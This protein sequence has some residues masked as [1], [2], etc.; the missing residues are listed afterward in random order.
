MSGKGD[1]KNWG[2]PKGKKKFGKNNDNGWYTDL[3]GR[4]ERLIRTTVCKQVGTS[5]RMIVDLRYVEPT[6]SFTGAIAF[7]QV[8]NLNSLQDPDVTGGGHQ[9]QF[10]D[11]WS[12]FYN[13]YRVLSTLVE[14]DFINNSASVVPKLGVVANNSVTSMVTALAFN[15]AVEGPGSWMKLVSEAAGM[16]VIRYRRRFYPHQVTG[17][18]KQQ[19]DIDDRFQ[20]QFSASPAESICL[21]IMAQDFGF[22][23]NVA[24]LCDVKLTYRAELWDRV[25]GSQS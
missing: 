11:Q 25:P 2:K 21:H 20:A 24:V 3:A 7:D 4:E 19:Y 22:G 9:P 5:D 6:L 16:N 10:F 1:R 14:I 12:G 15:N 17:V 18:T 23:S 8:Y 13:R